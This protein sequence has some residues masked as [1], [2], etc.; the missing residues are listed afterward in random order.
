MNQDTLL[1]NALEDARGIYNEPNSGP[2]CP[3]DDLLVDHVYNMLSK[4]KH[5]K[6]SE[7][8]EHC[9]HCHVKALKIEADRI[10]W[11]S[12]LDADPDHALVDALGDSGAALL[13]VEE[14]YTTEVKRSPVISRIKEEFIQWFSPSWT[15]LWAGEHVTAMDIPPREKSFVV[16]DGEI[17][18]TCSWEGESHNEPAY[19]RLTWKAFLSKDSRLWVR[20][21]DPDTRELLYEARLGEEP[22]GV[23]D[24]TSDELDFDPSTRRWEISLIL[25]E[26]GK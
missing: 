1:E 25:S 13:R 12:L 5:G 11:E 3:S 21:F 18:I 26:A 22:A 8:A 16:D 9:D 7:H 24:F 15:P 14:I 17:H 10:A 20:F 4:D 23:E 6:I 2:D 19:I